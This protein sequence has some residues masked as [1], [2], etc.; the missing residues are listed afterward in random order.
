VHRDLVREVLS[1]EEKGIPSP[2]APPTSW[3]VSARFGDFCGTPHPRLFRLLLLVLNLVPVPGVRGAVAG[4]GARTRSDEHLEDDPAID[5]ELR[6]EV[7]VRALSASPGD[8]FPAVSHETRVGN[9][10]AIVLA[11]DL[12]G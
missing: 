5:K 8:L 12:G 9:C 6:Q 4:F 7:R 10:C 11:V 1:D 2:S 3:I